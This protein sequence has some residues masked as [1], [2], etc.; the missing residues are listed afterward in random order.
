MVENLRDLGVTV[1][2]VKIIHQERRQV[3]EIDLLLEEE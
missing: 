3:I 1:D 2:S